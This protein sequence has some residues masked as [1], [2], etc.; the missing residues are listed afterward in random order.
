MGDG[1]KQTIR[2]EGILGLRDSETIKSQLLEAIQASA[3]VHIDA[4]DLAEVDVSV[5]QLLIA[6][7]KSAFLK[8]TTYT[9]STPANGALAQALDRGGFLPR[10]RS[11]RVST[12]ASE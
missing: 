3:A 7:Q 5:I 6:A 11:G 1:A 2:L 9:L 12:S 8:G 10:P 4:R